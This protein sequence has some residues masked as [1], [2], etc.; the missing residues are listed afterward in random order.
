M[1]ANQQWLGWDG[2]IIEIRLDKRLLLS[3]YL[4]ICSKD[5]RARLCNAFCTD[6]ERKPV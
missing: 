3:N 4:T 2:F 6:E 1:H 5:H